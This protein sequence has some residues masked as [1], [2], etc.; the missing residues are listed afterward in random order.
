MAVSEDVVCGCP[1]H[2]FTTWR[3]FFW[4]VEEGITWHNLNCLVTR[5]NDGKPSKSSLDNV[6]LLASRLSAWS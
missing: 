2:L 6:N 1:C 3:F 5:E 4:P